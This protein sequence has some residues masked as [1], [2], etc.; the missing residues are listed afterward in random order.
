MKLLHLIAAMAIAQMASA[1]DFCKDIKK[2]V[3]DNKMLTEYE[4]PYKESALPLIRVKRSVSVDE[5]TPFDNFVMVFRVIC[6]VDDIY[7]TNSDG[8]KT[9][10]PEKRLTIVFDDNTR[11]VDDTVDVMHDITVDRT[12]AIRYI[13]YP[14]IPETVGDLS[15]KK[16][17][18]FVIAGQEVP[19]PA[20][21]ANAIM[22]YTKCIRN[23]K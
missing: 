13:Y 11:I 9:E 12:E 16:I 15:S 7:A 10:K 14:V 22:Q 23:A 8:G 6:G 1:Q 4:S 5:D 19:V 21:N 2:E 3:S 20:D 17:S 18:K